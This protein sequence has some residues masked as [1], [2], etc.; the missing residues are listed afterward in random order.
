MAKNAFKIRYSNYFLFVDLLSGN[1]A[2]HKQ[3]VAG[4]LHFR[5]TGSYCVEFPMCTSSLKDAAGDQA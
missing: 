5:F 3:V 2:D 4:V 1:G